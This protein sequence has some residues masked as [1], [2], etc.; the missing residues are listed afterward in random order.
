M[1]YLNYHDIDI[2]YDHNLLLL[3]LIFIKDD[4]MLLMIW[5]VWLQIYNMGNLLLNI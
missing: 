3:N 4:I 1:V 2:Q 5:F